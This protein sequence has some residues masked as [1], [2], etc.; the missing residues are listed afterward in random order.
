MLFTVVTATVLWAG[1]YYYLRVDADS[2]KE[3]YLAK[4][5]KNQQIAWDATVNTHKIGMSAYF[6][7][8]IMTPTVASYM[9]YANS[10]EPSLRNTA[11]AGL[12][13]ELYPYYLKLEERNVRQLHFQDRENNSFLRFHQ[14][15]RFGDSLNSTRPSIV[16]ANKYKKVVQGFETGKVV[17]GFRN[18]FP[19]IYNGEHLGSVELSQPFSAIKNELGKLEPSKEYMM[20]LRA[21]EILPKIFEEQKRFYSKSEFSDE[22]LIEDA[23][24]ELGGGKNVLGANSIELSKAL[25]NHADFKAMLEKGSAFSYALEHNGQMFAATVTPIFDISGRY[26]AA[27]I[28]FMPSKELENVSADFDFRLLHFSAMLLIAAVALF[29]LLHSRKSLDSEKKRLDAISQTMGEGLYV[30][31]RDGKI[32]YINNAAA[33]ML[34]L[35]TDSAVGKVAHYLFH[36]H[37]RNGHTS[38]ADCPIY[39]TVVSGDKYA[40]VDSFTR[41]DG[42]VFFVDV[43]SSPLFEDGEIVG[44]VAV[45]RDI[46][47]RLKLENEL[48]SLNKELEKRVESEV[49]K[50]FE[51]E[52]IF[53]AIFDNS[54]E[55]V[56]I[57]GED[58][59]FAE[60]NK[61][62]A[63]ML[64]MEVSDI[65]GKRPCEL[66]PEIQP[67]SGFFSENAAK[68]FIKAA[69]A[70]EN[71]RF[72]WVHL[73]RGGKHVLV[74]V[75][76]SALNRGQKT[77]L[78]VLWRDITKIR[79]LQREQE[80]QHALL[81]Q[82]NKLAE[83]G[84]MIGAIA[85]QWKQPLNSIWLMAQDV[86]IS[87][88][89]NELTPEYMDKFKKEMGEQIK[90]MNQT[91]EDFRSFYKPSKSVS[92]FELKKAVESVLSLVKIQLD[93]NKIE[94]VSDMCDGLNIIGFES[95]FKQ[96]VLNIANNAKDA[97][98]NKDIQNKEIFVR[99]HRDG[100]KAILRIGDNA[101]GIDDEL[102]AGNKLFEP[103][104]TTK[105]EKGTG[106]GLSLSKT[107]VERRLNGKISAR[108]IQGGAEFVI[109]LPL[110]LE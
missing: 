54:P 35:T 16:L 45:F 78:L 101:G 4:Q 97:F 84:S 34:M 19:I 66:S 28:S 88:D 32:K 17:S 7:A 53:R 12:Y 104:S 24:D 86:K 90:F 29:W 22:W 11:R 106:V 74:E 56:L 37:A 59:R 8:Y 51:S 52:A 80:S 79:E 26:A 60:C 93:K 96:V 98:E 73:N 72:E 87:Y 62:A 38:L 58:G 108:N 82:Q 64:G 20:V 76:L 36:S 18:V 68:M 21:S 109:E 100:D 70:G 30:I 13:R 83:M 15:E 65:V 27:L 99:L 55:G 67:E 47:D 25:K 44:S 71:Q 63:S 14:K 92:K 102:L 31:D 9:K 49:E 61:A 23:K 48:R 89:M 75:V 110:A 57:I 6:D 5:T 81:M 39:K 42:S 41:S 69:M 107:I 95:E 50:R 94:I 103:Y 10:K 77:E 105:G 91:I 85:H 43:I 40:G 33:D 46:T 1:G 2:Q 3:F